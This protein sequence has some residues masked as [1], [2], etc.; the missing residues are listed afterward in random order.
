MRIEVTRGDRLGIFSVYT[1]GWTLLEGSTRVGGPSEI[2]FGELEDRVLE[3][4]PIAA[5][6]GPKC[7]QEEII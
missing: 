3:G 4:G 1:L 6:P 7:T 5:I 2:V